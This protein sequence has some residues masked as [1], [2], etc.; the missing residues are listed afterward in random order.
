ML[1]LYPLCTCQNA[2]E[3]L[4]FEKNKILNFQKQKA[5]IESHNRT[6]NNKNKKRNTFQNAASKLLEAIG[7]DVNSPTCSDTSSSRR[8]C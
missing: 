4:G 1:H 3:I 7:G 8:D 2:V 6:A 5:R